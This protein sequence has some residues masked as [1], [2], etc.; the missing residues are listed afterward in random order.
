MGNFACL[1]A[2]VL[3]YL[4]PAMVLAGC[5]VSKSGPVPGERAKIA[6]SERYAVIIPTGTESYE[7]LALKYYGDARLA[8]LIREQN[9]NRSLNGWHEIVIPLGSPNPG[10]LYRDGYLTV[11][12]L[13]YHHFDTPNAGAMNVSAEAFAAQ[14]AYLQKN[15]YQVISLDDILAFVSYQ[16]RPPQKAVV[17]TIDDGWKSLK[18]VAAP[19][20][21][22]HGF[23]A[24]LFVNSD[25]ISKPTKNSLSWED[26]RELVAAGVLDVQSHSVS[27]ADL[28]KVSEAQ[29]EQELAESKRLIEQKTGAKV[30]YFAYPYGTF[31][32]RVIEA[33][34]RQGYRLGLTV[35]R[36][37]NAFFFDPYAL[38]RSMIYAS[39]TLEEFTRQLETFR[40][41]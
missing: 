10:G 1:R 41:D 20:L 28:T 33:I 23:R 15:G 6:R 18:T 11:P 34:K 13:S 39:F 17:I 40:R 7:A 38:N 22:R 21:K 32:E 36:G 37:G 25:L 35:V 14:M 3:G 9:D 8:Y 19:I 29:L 30:R 16:R 5:S 26:I 27:H 31:N 2:L 4:L 12:I 24:T